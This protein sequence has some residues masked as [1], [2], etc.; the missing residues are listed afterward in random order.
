MVIVEVL[1][2]NERRDK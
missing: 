2:L 1:D